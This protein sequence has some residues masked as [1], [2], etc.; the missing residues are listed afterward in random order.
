MAEQFWEKYRDRRWQKKR[1]EIMER[2]G[3]RCRDCDGDDTT[4]LNVHHHYYDRG[5][6]P[7][8]YPDD[9]LITLCEPC[10]ERRT[11]LIQK[12]RSALG[13]AGT[14]WG[15]DFLFGVVAGISFVSAGGI[16]REAVSIH[17]K[18]EAFAAGLAVWFEGFVSGGDLWHILKDQ[19]GH[20]AYADIQEFW[21]DWRESHSEPFSP[22]VFCG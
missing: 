21:Q 19:T 16:R 11:E 17:L 9:A 20:V 13:E 7:W 2:D 8:D 6:D 12:F 22:F 1:L 15:V 10:H 4:V 18:S 3:W 5:A 14:S